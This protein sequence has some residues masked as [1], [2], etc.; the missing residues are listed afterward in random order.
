MNAQKEK[1]HIS[2]MNYKNWLQLILEKRICQ[3]SKSITVLIK[4]RDDHHIQIVFNIDSKKEFCFC[5]SV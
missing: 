1:E 3:D 5:S 4:M 2:E